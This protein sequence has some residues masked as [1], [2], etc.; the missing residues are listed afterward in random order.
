MQ[1]A[2]SD[3]NSAEDRFATAERSVQSV[4]AE[5]SYRD[6]SAIPMSERPLAAPRADHAAALFHALKARGIS[7]GRFARIIG[8]NKRLAQKYLAGETPIPTTILE[9]GVLPYDVRADFLARMLGVP[10]I[11]RE[12]D[13]LDLEGALDAQRRIT[14]RIATLARAPKEGK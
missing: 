5:Q 9:E 4:V 12:I 10:R 6:W 14:A 3:G 7:D 2:K 1:A 13:R 11:E 8:V